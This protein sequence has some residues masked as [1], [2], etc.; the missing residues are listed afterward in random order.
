MGEGTRQVVSDADV[1]GIQ[2]QP[3]HYREDSGCKQGEL[4]NSSLQ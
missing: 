4:Q 2:A 1:H 3:L